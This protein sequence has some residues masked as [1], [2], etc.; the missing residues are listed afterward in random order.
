MMGFQKETPFA[1]ADFSGSM[2]S[3]GVFPIIITLSNVI[4]CFF[5]FVFCIFRNRYFQTSNKA[6]VPTFSVQ[7]LPQTSTR[8][9]QKNSYK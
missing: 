5:C 8:W 4:N 7:K 1:L 3:F 2:L 9:A 6:G